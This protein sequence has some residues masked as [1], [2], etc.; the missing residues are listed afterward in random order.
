M[1]TKVVSMPT[2][3]RSR[4]VPS[5]RYAISMVAV[6]PL[7]RLKETTASR[8]LEKKQGLTSIDGSRGLRSQPK[9]TSVTRGQGRHPGETPCPPGYLR[10]RRTKP[11]SCSVQYSHWS[12]TAM[13][14]SPKGSDSYRV[15]LGPPPILGARTTRRRSSTQ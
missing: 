2:A 6:V 1:G 7:V 4:S 5:S 15:S 10:M 13:S 9:S 12:S 8:L 14:L 3:M 11:L